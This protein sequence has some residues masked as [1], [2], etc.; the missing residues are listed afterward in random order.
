MTHV[1]K[2]TTNLGNPFFVVDKKENGYCKITLDNNGCII[3]ASVNH[4]T[5]YSKDNIDPTC[6]KDAL[7]EMIILS[8][9]CFKEMFEEIKSDAQITCAKEVASQRA[10]ELQAISDKA[11]ESVSLLKSIA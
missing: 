3:K 4:C 6:L 7:Y 2:Q 9:F 10:K 8:P 1:Y 11:L 5:V